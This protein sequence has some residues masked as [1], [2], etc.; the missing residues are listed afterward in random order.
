M[1]PPFLN[2]ALDVDEWSASH[3]GPIMPGV[4]GWTRCSGRCG[5][6]KRSLSST[7]SRNSAFQPVARWYTD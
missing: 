3:P 4:A 7:G 1:A 6:E 5:G 2:P